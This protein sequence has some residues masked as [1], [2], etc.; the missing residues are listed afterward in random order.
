VVDPAVRLPT[1]HQLRLGL[2]GAL[3]AR[4]AVVG[5]RARQVRQAIVDGMSVDIDD[6]GPDG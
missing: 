1:E 4:P 2:A 3:D 5:V 6:A